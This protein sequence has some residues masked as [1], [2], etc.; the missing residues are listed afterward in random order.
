MQEYW[1]LYMKNIEGKPASIQFNAG[2][3]MD[4][5]DIK[6]IYPI[7]SFV[8]VELMNPN[9]K[10]LLSKEEQ[11]EIFFMEDKLEA[12]MLKFRLGKYVARIISGGFITFIYYIQY[13]YSWDDF[14]ESAFNEHKNYKT[15]EGYEDDDQWN[16]YQKLIYPN[17]KEWQIIH[18]HKVCDKLKEAGDNL[19]IARIIEHKI[20][21]KTAINKENLKQDLVK[22][23]FKIDDKEI[24]KDGM[25][26]LNFSRMNKVFY[27]DIDEIT[28]ELIEVAK[29]YNG[30]YDGWISEVVKI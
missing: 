22:Q 6:H 15:T 21:L 2:I 23:G 17:E 8:K 9:E 20:F 5:E 4:M 7:V 13:T 3:S 14:L 29:K 25:Q 11:E 27:Y 18:N 12:S 28:L 26:G 16:Y 30:L 10:G 24:N 19:L 1:E